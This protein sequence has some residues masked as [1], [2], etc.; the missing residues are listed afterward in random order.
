MS[1][2]PFKCPKCLRIHHNG[3]IGP[4]SPDIFECENCG[5]FRL[6]T[7]V[8]VDG[9][10]DPIQAAQNAVAAIAIDEVPE[11][12]RLLS[13]TSSLGL[14][15]RVLAETLKNYQALLAQKQESAELIKN[16]SR[17]VL[18]FLQD[19]ALVTMPPSKEVASARAVDDEDAGADADA[20]GGEASGIGTSPSDPDHVFTV[21]VSAKEL[22][23]LIEPMLLE[24]NLAGRHS[25]RKAVLR[26]FGVTFDERSKHHAQASLI[27]ASPEHYVHQGAMA[28]FETASKMVLHQAEEGSENTKLDS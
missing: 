20:G 19:H 18:K 23:G 12:I 3:P 25:G 2:L 7:D 1:H 6:K 16:K 28:A 5:R 14:F 22:A 24:A 27:A 15:G 21:D 8:K 13:E 4:E 26:A 17:A 11:A 9:L 10:V